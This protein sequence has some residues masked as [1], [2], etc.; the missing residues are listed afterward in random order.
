MIPVQNIYY[1]LAYAFQVLNEQG[2]KDIATEKFNNVGELC[3]KILAKGVKI[4]LKRGLNKEYVANKEALSSLRGRINITDSIKNQTILK[5]QMVCTFDDFSVNTYLNQIL[6]TTIKLLLLY[7][8]SKTLKN[9]LRKLLVYFDGIDTL[10]VNTIKWKI[11]FNRNNQ[12]YRMLVSICYLV[13]KG[14]L[15]TNSDGSTRLMDFIDEQRM[16]RLY[17]KF[18][19]E[20]YRKEF[21][22]IIE[23]NASH[24]DWQLDDENKLFLPI[25][26]SDI[27]LSKDDKVL[28]IDAKYYSKIVQTRYDA[29]TMHSGNLYQIFTY[30]KNKE[31]E[32]KDEP[33]N[34]SGMLLYAKTDEVLSPDVSYS[35]SGNKIIVKTLDLNCDFELISQQ[36]DAIVYEHILVNR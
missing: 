13:V 8:I 23:V 20:Y 35:M 30:V 28:I 33:H 19:F 18:I 10:D 2:Y 3:A 5:K 32:L 16:S 15:Q 21:K 4:Q 34:V 14:L 27:T 29:Q 9:E 1:M 12:N 36:L 26:K 17:E 25:M 31:V 7:D 22:S 24:I 6:K 11:D